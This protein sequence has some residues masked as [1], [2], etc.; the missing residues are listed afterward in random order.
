[1]AFQAE[2]SSHVPPVI[3]TTV[4]ALV[5]EGRVKPIATTLLKGL[6]AETMKSAHALVE[7][8]RTVG[9]VVITI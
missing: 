8:G 7:S 9:K 4:A 6:T 2:G 5:V 3:L 1:M